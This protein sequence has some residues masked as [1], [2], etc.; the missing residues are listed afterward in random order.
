M[1]LRLRRAAVEAAATAAVMEGNDIWVRVLQVSSLAMAAAAAAAAA[2]GA[3]TAC[4]I[5]A[6]RRGT[7]TDGL[8]FVAPRSISCTTRPA[9]AAVLSSSAVGQP[10]ST[11]SPR[12]SRVGSSGAAGFSAH[13]LKRHGVGVVEGGPGRLQEEAGETSGS[14]GGSLA[15]SMSKGGGEDEGSR[16]G[17]GSG[18]SGGGSEDEEKARKLDDIDNR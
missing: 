7:V 6:P 1:S 11:F 5:A 2:G 18:G 15:L 16:G 13:W 14:A 4:P 17:G 12:P 3:P 8:S 9:A 10:T